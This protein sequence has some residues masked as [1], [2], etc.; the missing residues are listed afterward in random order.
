MGLRARDLKTFLCGA[1]E[2]GLL[3]GVSDRQVR[4]YTKEGMPQVARGKFDAIACVQWKLAQVTEEATVTGELSPRDELAIAQRRKVELET[5]QLRA[6]L[7]PRDLVNRAINQVAAL[8]AAQLDGLAPRLA[9]ELADMH[10][11]QQIQ[12]AL[13]RE[14]RTTRSAIAQAM[15]ELGESVASGHA[16][17]DEEVEDDVEAA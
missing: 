2:I 5:A 7:L 10:D 6:T 8:V 13:L 3:L 14:A 15:R 12:A 11:P 1:E 9:G 4:N 16:F 17:E